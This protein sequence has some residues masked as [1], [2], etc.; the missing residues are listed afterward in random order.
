[1]QSSYADDL[2]DQRLVFPSKGL[3]PGIYTFMYAI[4]GARKIKKSGY[5]GIHRTFPDEG[6]LKPMDYQG[7]SKV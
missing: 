4:L 1:M 5:I 2:S 7:S 3:D 6:L